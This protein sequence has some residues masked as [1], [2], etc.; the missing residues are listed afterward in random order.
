MTDG[1]PD[2]TAGNIDTF[3]IGFTPDGRA[4]SVADDTLYGSRDRGLTWAST[5][6]APSK[7][8]MIAVQQ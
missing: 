1:F 3:H 7:I 4:W 2:T 6:K 8:R 5:W